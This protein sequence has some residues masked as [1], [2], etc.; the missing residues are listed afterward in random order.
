MQIVDHYFAL[1]YNAI[2][3]PLGLN[4]SN[5]SQDTGLFVSSDFNITSRYN[6]QV[7]NKDGNRTDYYPKELGLGSYGWY[8]SL[9]ELQPGV[10]YD[11]VLTQTNG[12][13]PF[14][15]R[16]PSDWSWKQELQ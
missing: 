15:N 10:V 12:S 8:G 16:S 1:P 9:T 14:M 3:T 13:I 7:K 5:T 2:S 6:I 11:I 4:T